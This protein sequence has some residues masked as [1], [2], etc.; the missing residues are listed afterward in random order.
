LSFGFLLP[1][2]F[3][4]SVSVVEARAIKIKRLRCV[5][6]SLKIQKAKTVQR[7]TGA[8]RLSKI[9]AKTEIGSRVLM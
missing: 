4:L 2:F 9:P 5:H 1:L 6:H 7:S 8:L 3:V